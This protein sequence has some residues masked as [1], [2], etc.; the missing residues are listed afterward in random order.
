MTCELVT[1][2]LTM[3]VQLRRPGTGLL[4]HSDRGN[5]YASELYQR[6][7]GR[8]RFVCS[9]S[10]KG[11]CWDHC[12]A[13]SFFHTLKAELIC[14]AAYLTRA[15]ARRE[16]FEFIEL[17]YN[18]VRRHSTLNYQTPLQYARQQERQK[19]ARLAAEGTEA[20]LSVNNNG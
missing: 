9:M 13:D 12:V 7:L 5:Q 17:F 4:V 16:L 1:S 3:V 20:Y 14:H 8:H 6:Y 11:H 2:A 19:K 15:Q 10:R 18:R